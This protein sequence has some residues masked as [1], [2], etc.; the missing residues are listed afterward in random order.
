VER[1]LLAIL[2][3]ADQEKAEITGFEIEIKLLFISPMELDYYQGKGGGFPSLETLSVEYTVLGYVH[4]VYIKDPQAL[5]IDR[6]LKTRDLSDKDEGGL[7]VGQQVMGFLCQPLMPPVDETRA[8][9][10]ELAKDP[11]RHPNEMQ[12]ALASAADLIR[13]LQCRV[14]GLASPV[15]KI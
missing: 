15:C 10:E 6:V 1:H 11:L 9:C 14:E 13:E 8:L 5:M 4:N 3:C 2:S 7:N 12:M